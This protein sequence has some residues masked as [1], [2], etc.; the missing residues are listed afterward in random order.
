M[1]V[2]RTCAMVLFREF[3]QLETEFRIS[4]P[5][6]QTVEDVMNLGEITIQGTRHADV[7]KLWL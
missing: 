2:A 1:Y 7:L 6:M 3:Q 5:Y 4:A